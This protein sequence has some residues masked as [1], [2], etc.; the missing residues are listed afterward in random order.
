M[1]I[2]V[3]G[4]GHFGLALAKLLCEHHHDVS[5]WVRNAETKRFMELN[6]KHP[7]RFTDV[8]LP[9]SLKISN[10]LGLATQGKD[11]VITAVPMVGLRE[12][13]LGLK[14]KIAANTIV[15][16]VTKGI[17]VQTHLFPSEIFAELLPEQ[18]SNYAFLSGPSFAEEVLLGKMTA[19][20]LAATN[21]H[22]RQA[23]GEAFAARAFFVE[24]L[25]DVRGLEICAAVKNIAAIGSG[26]IHGLALGAN[27]QA[28]FTVLALREMRAALGALGGKQST[29]DALGGVGDLVL[30]CYGQASRNRVVG[31]QIARGEF[32]GGFSPT[33]ERNEVAEGVG[34]SLSL[35]ERA[36]KAKLQLPICS[37]VKK[38]IFDGADP[39][40]V[41][42]ALFEQYDD[43]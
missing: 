43:Q 14:E 1:K 38:L 13:L 24:N 36:Q 40:T 21:S 16:G 20:S 39:L 35:L 23:A 10:D 15:L 6:R 30:T 9:A 22:V 3:L 26:V 12:L 5:I 17:E 37:A 8:M 29:V 25:D 18:I 28:A 7:S 11:L 41:I 2:A 27:A 4:A 42:G 33:R 34:A 19:V 32:K 31:I